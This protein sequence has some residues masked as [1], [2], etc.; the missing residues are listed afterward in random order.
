MIGKYFFVSINLRL[1]PKFGSDGIFETKSLSDNEKLLIFF[2]S[3]NKV[4]MINIK[5]IYRI[6]CY[7]YIKI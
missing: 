3:T 1:S 5:L 2:I 6:T 7:F 4:L